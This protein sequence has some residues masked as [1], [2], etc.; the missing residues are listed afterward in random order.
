MKKESHC[1]EHMSSTAGNVGDEVAYPVMKD[2][3]NEAEGG[4]GALPEE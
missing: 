1:V 2:I 3:G 4:S